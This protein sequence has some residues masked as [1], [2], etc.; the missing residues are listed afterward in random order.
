MARVLR[1]KSSP[2]VARLLLSAREGIVRANTLMRAGRRDPLSPVGREYLSGVRDALAWV[3]D[4]DL[5]QMDDEKGLVAEVEPIQR[6][7]IHFIEAYNCYLVEFPPDEMQARQEYRAEFVSQ[8][9]ALQLLDELRDHVLGRAMLTAGEYA[10]M[11]ELHDEAHD[12]VTTI[13]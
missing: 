6:V 1:V 8:R 4:V 2:N 13:R 5:H 7:T 11:A 12:E 9:Q 10:E 3:L